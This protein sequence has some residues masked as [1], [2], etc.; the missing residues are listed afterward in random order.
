MAGRGSTLNPTGR[1]ERL[2]IEQDPDLPPEERPSPRTVFLK[3]ASRSLIT[4]NDSPDIPFRASINPYR[5][6]EHGCAYCYARP[7]HEYLGFSAGLDFESKIM[8]KLDAARLLR[9]ELARPKW[10]PQ[11]V[12]IS[13]VTDCYQPAERRFR[14]T[15]QCLEVFLE[16]RNPVGIVTKNSLVARDADVLSEL[17]RFGCAGV[18]LSITTLKPD[19]AHKLEP[20]AASPRQRLETV[21]RLR[22]AGVPVSVLLAPLIPGLNDEEVPAILK[23]AA[24][25]GAQDA[26]Y[27]LLRLPHGVKD[28]FRDWVRT[29]APL[30]ESRIFGLIGD[31]RGGKESDSTWGQRM[32]GT[33]TYARQL[34]QLFQ[35]AKGKAGLGRET[36]E[37]T[38]RHFRRPS[39][40]QLTFEW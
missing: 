4:W 20:R 7:T 33:G 8:V 31:T 37:W 40:N 36:V 26:G 29:H 22:N 13:G 34:R 35:V 24:E 27:V 12:A 39:G 16:C 30:K 9:E 6:C 15:R 17:A 2:R 10:E 25:A 32:T 38:T 19:L 18:H 5:G 23:A 11:M 28:I 1:F 21:T 3:D 14:L